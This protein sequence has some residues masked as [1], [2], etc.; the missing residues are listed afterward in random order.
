[1]RA[2]LQQ[3]QEIIWTSF[4]LCGI[5]S[6]QHK[7]TM[8]SALLEESDGG[9]RLLHLYISASV[10]VQLNMHLETNTFP[11]SGF[12]FRGNIHHFMTQ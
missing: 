7:N 5:M 12:T 2:Q 4:F 6:T 8:S 3:P 10:R 9:L 1:M 11:H